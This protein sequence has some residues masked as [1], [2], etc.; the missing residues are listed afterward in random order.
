MLRV[1]QLMHACNAH[2]QAIQPPEMLEHQRY[3]KGID[4]WQLGCLMYLCVIHQWPFGVPKKLGFARFRQ[5]VLN[6]EC[7]V[8][9][10]SDGIYPGLRDLVE[11]CFEDQ[12]KRPS[13]DQVLMHPFFEG[14][15]PL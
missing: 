3:G 8:H 13:I 2:M 4:V 1:L 6:R 15:P 12:E 9:E 10:I 5:N 11:Q 7:D 14:M